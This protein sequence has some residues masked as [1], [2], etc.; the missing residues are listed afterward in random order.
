MSVSEISIHQAIYLRQEP[1]NLRLVASSSDFAEEWQPEAERL[2][3]GFGDRPAGVSCP[4][5]LFAQPFG[6]DHVAVVQVADQ[7]TDES[8]TPKILGFHFLILPRPFYVRWI[9]DPFAIA[10]RF[11]PSWHSRGDLPTLSWEAIPLPL[12][13]VA[14]V[15]RVLKRVD[16]VTG[17]A[18]PQSPT[19]LGGAQALVDGGRLV[20]ERPAPHLDL[21]RDLWALLPHST[22]C[23]LWPASFA[24]GNGLHFDAL[25]V[26]QAGGPEFTGYL[27]EEQAG[28]YPEGRYELNLQIAAETGD[29]H[30]LNAL[31]A[32]RSRSQTFRL[33]VILLIGGIVLLFAMKW[34]NALMVQPQH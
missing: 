14:E 11:P 9:G 22:R 17:A 26:P 30:Q 24:F 8:S 33:G 18:A 32:R 10:A 27:N 25:V 3:T 28:D 20:F 12:R 16:N 23:H 19:L 7:G 6:K 4:A 2:C 34:L 15:Q 13:T 31:F 21:I 1:S 5:G 29:Q